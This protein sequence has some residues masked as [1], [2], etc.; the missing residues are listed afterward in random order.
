MAR[1]A[2]LCLAGMIGAFGAAAPA[3]AQD[4][5]AISEAQ[6]TSKSGFLAE[7]IECKRK[8]GVL[9]IRMRIRNMSEKDD[10]ISVIGGLNYD[11]YYVTAGAKKYFILRDSEKHPLSPHADAGGA[12]TARI[13]KNGAWIWWA[14]YPAPPADQK[15]ITYYTPLAP[16]F[17][18]VPISD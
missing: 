15:K 5:K 10:S 6:A 1:L 12:V 2:A 7:M 11:Q 9:S 14:R 16:P 4:A 13:A 18:D 8:D 3:A 17:D